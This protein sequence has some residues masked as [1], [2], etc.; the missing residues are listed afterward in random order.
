MDMEEKEGKIGTPNYFIKIKKNN[1]G[2]IIEFTILFDSEWGR[3]SRGKINWNIKDGQDVLVSSFYGGVMAPEEAGFLLNSRDFIEIIG[4]SNE[5]ITRTDMRFI[6][7]KIKGWFDARSKSKIN[8]SM[9]EVHNV[10]QNLGEPFRK[11]FTSVTQDI[12]IT[13]FYNHI[14]G[15]EENTKAKKEVAFEFEYDKHVLSYKSADYYALYNEQA[16]DGFSFYD[17]D[18]SRSEMPFLYSSCEKPDI[19]DIIER[20]RNHLKDSDPCVS[21][22]IL[23][24]LSTYTN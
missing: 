12:N 1:L 11:C 23:D 2:L 15:S 7:R 17:V 13:V 21:S 9:Y 8:M 5:G 10:N 24:K 22:Y 16:K 18:D 4:Y 20:F 6:Y 3:I 14:N 19:K